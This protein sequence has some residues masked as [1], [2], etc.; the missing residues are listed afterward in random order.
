MRLNRRVSLAVLSGIGA[1]LTS[2]LLFDV[3]EDWVV[4]GN[5]LVSTAGENAL[6]FVLLSGLF[7][8]V[9]NL[10]NGAYDDAFVSSVATW[11]VAGALTTVLLVSWVVGIQSLQNEL[12]PWIIVLQ[13][14]VVGAG[15]GLLVGHNTARVERAR[16]RSQRRKER[17]ESLFENDPAAIVDLRFDDGRLVVEATNPEYEAQFGRVNGGEEIEPTL[18]GVD[19]ETMDTFRAATAAG[20]RHTTETTHYAP[21]GRKHFVVELV[22]YGTSEEHTRSYVLYQD[23]TEIREAEAELERT[24]EQLERS[25]EQLKQFAYVA[26]HD[27]QEPLRMVSSYVDL[28]ATEYE[29]ELDDEADEYIEF[30]VDGAQRMQ[31]MIDALL[32]Y[33]RVHTQGESFEE[34]DAETVLER[35]LR[36]LEL[37]ID[38]R[39]ATVTHDDLPAVVADEDQ[40][41]Q[42]FQNLISNAIEHAG[43]DDPPSVHVS[44]EDRDDAV[45]FSVADDGPGIPPAQQERIFEIFEQSDR[46]DEG[47]GIGLAIC[48]RIVDRHEG[49]IWVESAEG[50]GATF[51]VSFPKR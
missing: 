11:T 30:A 47:T 46:D 36:N 20:E 8:A 21:D 6:P 22:P 25:N 33:S 19:A 17:F 41:G 7:Y 50:E 3:Y 51:Y 31:A 38:E 1:A 12:K 9:W 34:V 26:S 18:P 43:D 42:V 39:D 48:Q 15:A 45:V 32:T 16:D 28:L 40:L 4:Q 2:V 35:V 24:V 44:G 13:T 5:T 29:G 14:T 23:V 49:D 10:R 27:L 37:L